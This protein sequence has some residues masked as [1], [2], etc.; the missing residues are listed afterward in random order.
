MECVVRGIPV[1]YE[2]MGTGRPVLMLHG[3]PSDHHLM[4]YDLEHLFAGRP[5]WRRLYPDLPGMGKTPGADWITSQDDMLAVVLEFLDAVAPGERVVVI[6]ASYG[7][8]LA[9]GVLHERMA[10]MDGLML[11]A[12]SVIPDDGARHLPPPQTLVRDAD[13]PAAL[14]LDE[15]FWSRIAVVQTA[16]TLAAFRAAVKPGFAAADVSFLE[17]LESAGF[18][19]SFAVGELPAPFPAPTLILTGRQ[20]SLVGY[21]DA[22]GLVENYPRA[23]FV[24]LDRAGHGLAAEQ[25]ILF[26]ALVGEWLDRVT[27]YIAGS[28]RS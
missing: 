14:E 21:Q 22:W 19:F 10:R 23:T 5:G 3:W 6:G 20:D 9:R 13:I 1:Y 8:F 18:V 17:R 16:E 24:T 12:P 25:K 4:T 27:E 2:D 7:G 26:Q 28:D 11:L 15:T